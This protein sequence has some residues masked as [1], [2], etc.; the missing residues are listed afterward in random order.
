[1]DILNTGQWCFLAFLKHRNRI[2]SFPG[3][4]S[5]EEKLIERNAHSNDTQGEEMQM[6]MINSVIG[7]Y[8]VRAENPFTFL[9]SGS[10]NY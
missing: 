8:F 9:I 4:K 1:M 10:I 3:E 6:A 2:C 5:K 7:C